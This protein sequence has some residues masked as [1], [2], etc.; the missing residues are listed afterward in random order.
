MISITI[1][2]LSLVIAILAA[3]FGP[4]IAWANVQRQIGVAA[5]E[6]WMREFREQ[7]AALLAG[8]QMFVREAER[9]TTGDPEKQQRLDNANDAMRIPYHAI[10]LLVAERGPQH[11]EL[12]R[13]MEAL[14]RTPRDELNS[15]AQEVTTAAAAILQ[16]ERAATAA[17]PG[18]WRMLLTTLGVSQQPWS[19]LVAWLRRNLP[20]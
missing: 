8:H 12:A 14:I 18:V 2:I 11:A 20:G 10:R 19:R 13:A 3:F 9:H 6:A 1:S 15:R 7:V 5:G 17:D 16:S 4:L